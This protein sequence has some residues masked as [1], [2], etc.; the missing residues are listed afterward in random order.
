MVAAAGNDGVSSRF[1]PAAIRAVLAVG[2]SGAADTRYSWS[3]YG[4]RWVD[5][6]A[7]GCNLA[8][9]HTGHYY[10]F[11]GTSSAT[12]LVAGVAALAP[13]PATRAR[14]PPR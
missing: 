9:G 7:P 5:V 11:C 14:R 8:Q 13:W 3:N 1:Y 4:A 6:A 12:P 2:A 10:D